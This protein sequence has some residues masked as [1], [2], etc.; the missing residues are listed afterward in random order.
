MRNQEIKYVIFDYLT[1]K[2]QTY[3]SNGNLVLNTKMS[4]SNATT[5]LQQKEDS[6]SILG[7]TCK[8]I[9]I[10]RKALRFQNNIKSET[11]FQT[12]IWV[13][14]DLTFQLASNRFNEFFNNSTGCIALYCESENQ[15]NTKSDVNRFKLNIHSK[16]IMRAIEIIRKKLSDDE[17]TFPPNTKFIGD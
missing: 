6:M 13:A 5:E 17:F 2:Y 14:N 1:G 8:K 11:T 4:E 10:Q 7:F 9:D 3:L 16:N 15:N 12:F